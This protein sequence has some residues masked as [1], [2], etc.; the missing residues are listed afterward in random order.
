MKVWADFTHY[1]MSRVAV[2]NGKKAEE[3]CNVLEQ[4]LH[5]QMK[6]HI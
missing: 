5:L 4:H 1:G 3:F 6:V 2:L